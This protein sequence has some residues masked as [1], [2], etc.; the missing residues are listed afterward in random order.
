[1]DV[2]GEVATNPIEV[3]PTGQGLN[4]DRPGKFDAPH[5]FT[6]RLKDFADKV[7]AEALKTLNEGHSQRRVAYWTVYA[8]RVL[9]FVAGLVTL[10]ASLILGFGSADHPLPSLG[11]AGLSVSSFIATFLI[12]PQQELEKSTLISTCLSLIVTSYWTRMSL[13]PASE[14]AEGHI[15][16]TT[17]DTIAHFE[18][19]SKLRKASK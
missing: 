12:R 17:L 5:D 4:A 9:L 10:V 2:K 13:L 6:R 3:A 16:R 18:R 8:M 14:Q 11:F 1:M 15:E 7:E 19:L